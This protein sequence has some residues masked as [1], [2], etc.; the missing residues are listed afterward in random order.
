MHLKL[1]ENGDAQA[2]PPPDALQ[3]KK[4]EWE[5]VRWFPDGTRF[6]ANAHVP[7][8]NADEWSSQG[9]SIWT[10]SILGVAP[11]SLRD[12]SRAYSISPDGSAI[13][14]GTNKGRLGDR[15]IWLMD[16]TGD[17]AGKFYETDENSGILGADWSP[18]GKLIQYVRVDATGTSTITRAFKGGSAAPPLFPP[19]LDNNIVYSTWLP[20]GRLIYSLREPEAVGVVSCNLWDVQLDGGTGKPIGEPRRLTNWSGSCV[21]HLSITADGHKLAF[22]RWTNTSTTHVADLDASGSYLANLRHFTLSEGFDWPADWTADGKA[23]IFSSN[24]TGQSGIYRQLLDEDEAQPLV[25]QADPVRDARV[26]ADG[27]WV[28]YTVMGKPGE[29]PAPEPLMRVPVASGPTQVVF[30]VRPHSLILCARSPSNLCATAEPTADHKQVLIT[31]FDPLKG[32][33]PELTRFALDP[34]DGRWSMDLSPDGNYI[35]AVPSP[36][37]PLCILSLHGE[38]MREI[39]V[40]GWSNLRSLSWAGD[41]KSLFVG[42]RQHADDATLLRVDLQ[43]NTNVL[44]E[45]AGLDKGF[46]WEQAGTSRAPASPDGRHLAIPSATTAQN[47]WML[48]NF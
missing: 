6:L 1:V 31:S 48:E 8:E 14:F 4:V 42:A 17:H 12:N 43:G 46:S 29:P 15:E 47:F 21:D 9:T 27:K 20:D 30:F 38:A 5:I 28:L 34:D 19:T 41:G 11:R 33:G 10:L 23:L 40:K 7:G 18:D 25:I 32:R 37:G 39:Q 44:S 36:A 2:I 13:S 35:A 3:R 24:R 22:L 45:H 26:S 16:P